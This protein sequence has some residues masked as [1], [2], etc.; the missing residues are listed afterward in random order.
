MREFSV[1][2]DIKV[3]P[4]ATLSDAVFDAERD[5][6]DRVMFR[7]KVAGSWEPVTAATFARQVRRLAAGLMARGVKPGD[8]IGLMSHTRYEWTL[9][10]YAIWTAG[11]V[12]VPVY[13]TSSAEQVAWILGDSGAV[14]VFVESDEHQATVGEV[15]SE[16]SALRHVWKLEGGALEELA[17]AGGAVTDA[18][19]EQRRKTP[20][21]DTLATVIYTSGT[22]GRPKGCELTHGNFLFD[23]ATTTDGLRELFTEGASTLLFLP[24]AHV[25]ARIIQ[26]GCV[27]N[28]ITM[29]H[30]SDVKNL[31]GDFA[32]FEPTFILA[33]PRIFEK[34]YNGAQQKAH[35]GGKAQ[36]VLFDQAD[37]TAVA[38][39]EQ[40]QKGRVGPLTK[41]Q[42][43]A[44]DKLV[45]S[46]LRAVMGGKVA[47][48]VSGGG[49]L[50][51]RLG[52][53]FRGIGVTVLEGYGLTETTAGATC[54]LP[55]S[56][57]VGSVGRP[58]PGETV[59][60]ADDGEIL[61]RGENIFRGYWKNPGAT[62]ETLAGGWF[63]TGDIG[64]LDDDGFLSITG[65]MKELIVT[66]GAHRRAV[67][68][69]GGEQVRPWHDRVL[70]R[71]QRRRRG[72]RGPADDRV[73]GGRAGRADLAPRPG[74]WRRPRP[75]R[76]AGSDA[77]LT[78]Y[79][80]APTPCFGVG[81]SGP[82]KAS[83]SR[84]PDTSQ[85]H[86][87]STQARPAVP[88]RSRSAGSS[89]RVTIRS[90]TAARSWPSTTKPVSPSSTASGAPPLFPA[91]TGR[92]VADA[93]RN[94]MP[95]PSTSRPPRR[96]RQGMANTSPAA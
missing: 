38:Y 15:A 62:A 8:R 9:C 58:I 84:R 40:L 70:R 42:H 16:L 44:F 65:R 49:P 28:R 35:A 78:P 59:R 26:V 64:Q 12:T 34:V 89:S 82:A 68:G 20:T 51:A 37:R 95:S 11:A 91:T 66:A 6:P 79:R 55:D 10:D 48:A 21:P 24:L 63:H 81:R 77:R 93:S 71:C 43:L 2:A 27:L 54:N 18:D 56:I 94:T 7:R 32:V 88:I 22:T 69:P 67:P 31:L 72:R 3:A 73:D 50:G 5:D 87:R 83:R 29:G 39:S 74:P 33:V 57:R 1:P 13:E 96:V 75:R 47:Y 36:G 76:V 25:F 46:R 45:Y 4:D 19:V 61:L 53:F 80:S 85:R 30:T 17:E 86:S 23:A 60:I 92:P 41:A 14:A 52:H 90:T